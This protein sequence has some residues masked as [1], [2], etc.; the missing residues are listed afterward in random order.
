MFAL[1][2]IFVLAVIFDILW[3]RPTA[4]AAAASI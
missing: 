2:L 3:S 1:V 4:H